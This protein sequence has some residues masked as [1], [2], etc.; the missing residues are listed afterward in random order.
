MDFPPPEYPTKPIKDL[1]LSFPHKTC[2]DDFNIHI[3]HGSRIAIIGRNGSGKTTLLKMLQ[4]EL[5]PTSGIIECGT[6]VV[7]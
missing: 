4:G 6:D 3:R 2:F 1:S 5:E 7:F